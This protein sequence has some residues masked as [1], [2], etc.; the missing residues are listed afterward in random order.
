MGSQLRNIGDDK[1]YAYL[2]GFLDGDGCITIRFEKSKTNRLG[3]C[4]RVRVSFT[5]HKTKKEILEY[6]CERI[7][8]GKVTVY[9]HNSM[10]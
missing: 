1:F 8:S 10:V 4:A 3:Y 7:G 9:K 6:I 2:A 5:Q